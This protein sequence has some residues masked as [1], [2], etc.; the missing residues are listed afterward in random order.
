MLLLLLSFTACK[1]DNT[2]QKEFCKK[3]TSYVDT[4]GMYYQL[5]YNI[6]G[7]LSELKTDNNTYAMSYPDNGNTIIVSDK[8]SER[9]FKLGLEG[10]ITALT[11]VNKIS[12]EITKNNYQR[13]KTDNGYDVTATIQSF[14][15]DENMPYKTVK[16]LYKMVLNN[17][18]LM[19]VTIIDLNNNNMQLVTLTYG[20]NF[21]KNLNEYPL[22]YYQDLI[23]GLPL[24]SKNLVIRYSMTDY[25][26][27]IQADAVFNHEFDEQDR[28]LNSTQ[29]S[30]YRQ[31]A[32]SS[33][34]TLKGK[35]EY[36]CN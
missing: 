8:F 5:A 36:K 11:S 7:K 28:L 22:H 3:P 17:G 14:R 34:S 1:K 10:E 13:V 20:Y 6:D 16:N 24:I 19:S 23:D 33:T 35:F 27:N 2:R 25:K 18:N 4:Q 26:N 32:E 31:G 29:E 21:S 9:T 30:V 12:G 15:K